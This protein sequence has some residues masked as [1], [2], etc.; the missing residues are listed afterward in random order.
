MSG[1]LAA[2]QALGVRDE[3]EVEWGRSQGSVE[4]LHAKVQR[5]TAKAWRFEGEM[6]EIAETFAE[7]GL[8][9]VC[10]MLA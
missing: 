5:V 4:E 6:A 3:F 10:L 9:D 2:A 8:P 7:L 1:T